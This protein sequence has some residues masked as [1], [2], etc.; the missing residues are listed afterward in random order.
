MLTN[1][2]MWSRDMGRPGQRSEDPEM[3]TSN[4]LL[5]IFGAL[6]AGLCAPAT[7]RSQSPFVYH[8]MRA[9]A[10]VEDV[11]RNASR[12]AGDNL[13]CHE[14]SGVIALRCGRESAETRTDGSEIGVEVI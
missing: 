9:G 4:R 12:E 13:V 2:S 10:G 14:V 6:A 1:P 7:V 3:S 11:K 5:C 8:G